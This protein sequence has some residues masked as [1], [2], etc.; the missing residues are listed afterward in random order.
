MVRHFFVEH[1]GQAV[2]GPACHGIGRAEP[3]FKIEG[4]DHGSPR[5]TGSQG[6]LCHILV[7]EDDVMGHHSMEIG[8]TGK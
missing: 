4:V 1:A 5:S 8:R 3:R 6:A 2:G 7:M